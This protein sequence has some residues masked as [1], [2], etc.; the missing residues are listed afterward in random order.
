MVE[1]QVG[2]SYDELLTLARWA[3][4]MGL[5]A[6]ARSDH[7]LNGDS[8]ERATDALA[9]IGGLARETDDVKLTVLVTP[10]T[11]RHPAVI[12]K[13]AATLDEMSGGRFELGVGT[14]WMESEHSQFG[15]ELPDLRTR[16]SLLY[17]TLAFV[18]T[19]F[20]REDDNTY[21][22]RH[23]HLDV[24]DV[25]P[26]PTGDLPIIV[27]GGG[28]EK[29]PRL[30]GRFA[31]EYNMFMTDAATL[32]SRLEHMRQSATEAGRDPDGI[33]ISM[34]SQVIGGADEAEYQERL[35]SIAAQRGIEPAELEA[36]FLG[37]GMFCGTHERLAERAAEVAGLGVERLYIQQFAALSAIDTDLIGPDIAAIR[38]A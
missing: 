15:M 14:G 32:A 33:R 11:F 16:F 2:G 17:E 20:G 22:G 6:F 13:T 38:D 4:E 12:A 3:D 31:D 21:R 24:T 27:G 1:P 5:V 26:R 8:S 23:F 10:L 9:S 36:N 19:A 7:Y 30:A 25:L 29:T 35:G 18:R 37:R 28:P 34:V